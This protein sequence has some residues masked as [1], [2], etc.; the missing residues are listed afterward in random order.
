MKREWPIHTSLKFDPL[1]WA[2]REGGGSRF[3]HDVGGGRFHPEGRGGGSDLKNKS[4]ACRIQQ[5]RGAFFLLGSGALPP[6]VHPWIGMP[7]LCSYPV[8][9]E[10]N[11]NH[12]TPGEN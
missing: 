11:C 2:G 4:C 8:K 12:D 10:H 9:P 7:T 5:K 6:W 3:G 1:E